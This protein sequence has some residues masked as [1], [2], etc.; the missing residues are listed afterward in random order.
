M[1]HQSTDRG[2]TGERQ[3]YILENKKDENRIVR[4][5]KNNKK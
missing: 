2:I 1:E 3:Y 5:K 4:R